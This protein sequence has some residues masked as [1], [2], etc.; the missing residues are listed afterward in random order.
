MPHF[1]SALLPMIKVPE[2]K[3]MY[4]RF[5]GGKILLAF[6]AERK[7]EFL[8]NYGIDPYDYVRLQLP[9][10]IIKTIERNK[11]NETLLKNY[12]SSCFNYEKGFVSWYNHRVLA[13]KYNLDYVPTPVLKPFQTFI[14]WFLSA[15]IL[16]ILAALLKNTSLIIS[17]FLCLFSGFVGAYLAV[18][19]EANRDLKNFNCV[20]IKKQIKESYS[21][22]P[23]VLDRAALVSGDIIQA[24]VNPSPILNDR[25][26]YTLKRHGG[27]QYCA[28]SPRKLSNLIYR[29]A[30]TLRKEINDQSAKRLFY[31]EGKY[32]FAVMYYMFVAKTDEEFQSIEKAIKKDYDYTLFQT[33]INYYKNAAESPEFKDC[34]GK[35]SPLDSCVAAFVKLVHTRINMTD[36]AQ[37]V[38]NLF[39]MCTVFFG[40]FNITFQ[41]DKTLCSDGLPLVQNIVADMYKSEGRNPVACSVPLKNLP[42]AAPKTD[43]TDTAYYECEGEANTGFILSDK[44]PKKE[45]PLKYCSRCGS[46]INSKTNACTGCGKQYFRGFRFT[47][48][49]TTVIVMSLVIA[50]VSTL[51]VFQY[52]NTQDRI[53][54]LEKQLDTK[55]SIIINLQEEEASLRKDHLKNWLKARFFDENAEI[56]GSNNPKYY[57]KYGCSALDTSDG[58][59]IYHTNAAIILGYVECPYCH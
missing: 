44:T 56:I 52:V 8:R 12:I 57:H 20:S 58:F 10:S 49:S 54:D 24:P 47:K 40:E 36:A 13:E 6:L 7:D 50:I 31:G 45:K 26:R 48:F 18:L 37:L 1:M 23:P 32:F 46:V 39:E 35:I 27:V 5:L 9:E 17:C 55:Q 11:D 42:K 41:S 3:N 25:N 4:L 53:N 34:G 15:F 29:Y 51:C 38:E 16:N 30:D 43:E 14:F 28:L 19:I 33:R 2:E 22:V 59:W 21:N